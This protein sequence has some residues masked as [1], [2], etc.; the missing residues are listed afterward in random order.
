MLE[1]QE[2]RVSLESPEM[3]SFECEREAIHLPGSIQPIGVLVAVAEPA[4]E[5]E[6]ISANAQE[7]LGVEASAALGRTLEQVLGE[8]STEILRNAA[9]GT[10]LDDNPLYLGTVTV[11]TRP[12]QMVA[13]RRNRVLVVE[14]EPA[15]STEPASFRSIYSLVQSFLRQ[16]AQQETVA[17]VA[18]LTT[19]EV[20]RLTGFDRVMVY[21]FD[22]DWNGAVI[23][24]DRNDVLPSYLGLH[25]P[26]GDIPRQA[27]ELYRI[28]HLRQITDANSVPVSLIGRKNSA[29]L[30]LTHASL[31]TVSPRH[32]EYM[33]N[34]GTMAS[35]SISILRD[36]ELWGLVT[37]H[38]A[39][40][41]AIPFETRTACE[42]VGQ[43]LSLEIT[44]AERRQYAAR[45]E[46]LKKHE[47]RLLSHLAGVDHLAPA[48][49]SDKEDLLACTGAAGAALVENGECT[50]VGQTPAEEEV[51]QVAEWLRATRPADSVFATEALQ[52]DY[53]G[54]KSYASIAS[55]VLAVSLSRMQGSYLLWFRPEVAQTVRWAGE[56]TGAPVL[57]S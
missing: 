30:D 5:V 20:R 21:R 25:F 34:M 57:V 24:E 9:I 42:F 2:E 35:M 10:Q 26:A 44:S 54:A 47:S 33:K 39:T 36:G 14:L 52:A 50:L 17:K 40:P 49:A 29:A 28:N 12:F 16:L 4:F 45:R 19:V 1:T 37:C 18:A 22:P 13:H 15:G 43:M 31:R 38:S 53:S 56:L 46:Q 23:A 41:R 55:G 3:D 7:W 48:L 6:Q 32:I 8:G 27:R 51:L 11:S